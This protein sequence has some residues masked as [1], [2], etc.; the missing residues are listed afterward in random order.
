VDDQAFGTRLAL[1]RERIA[2]AAERSGRPA[3]AVRLVGAGKT[4]PAEVLAAAVAAGVTDLGENRVQEAAAK[5]PRVR[6]EPAAWHLIGPLQMNKVPKAVTLFDC[7]Q[8]VDSL[9][10]AEK[11]ERVAGTGER[12]AMGRL[13]ILVEVNVSG[14]ATKFGVPPH[15]ARDLVG[16]IRA[17]CPRLSLTGLMTVGPRVEEPD[18]ARPAY[19]ALARLADALGLPERSM[20][21]SGDYE[22]AIEEGATMVRLG[23]ALFGDR[24][25]LAAHRP[26]AGWGKD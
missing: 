8:T 12:G 3:T 24:P 16:A 15:D 13:R 22:V 11:L 7:I 18:A 20:G 21:M 25:T 14:E 23:S 10:L 4:V 6:P 5:I 26:A 19:R 17:R 1:V 9:R 2:R